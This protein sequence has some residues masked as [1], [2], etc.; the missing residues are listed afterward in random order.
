VKELVGEALD[1]GAKAI[2]GAKAPGSRGFFYEPTVLAGV[3]D[4]FAVVRNE[5]FGPVAP[6]VT[7]DTE[8]EAIEMANGTEFGLV[9]FVHTRDLA[10]GLRVSERIAAWCPI[11]PRRSA[12][13]SK[14]ASDAKAPTTA[15]W[16]FWKRSTSP[17]R[18]NGAPN[19]R[20]DGGNGGR[21][22]PFL[23]PFVTY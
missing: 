12:A 10:R 11:P 4:D 6:I 23:P 2:V 1:R 8:D 13:G 18:G 19:Q 22:E 15:C 5:I 3:K 20:K 14:A 17:L 7:F 21:K 9:S 16:N